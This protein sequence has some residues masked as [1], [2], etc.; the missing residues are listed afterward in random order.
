MRH[1]P[2]E[3]I[4]DIVRS[5][6]LY[7]APSDGGCLKRLAHPVQIGNPVTHFD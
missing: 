1:T 2:E 7:L 4:L 5:E 3:H 6:N